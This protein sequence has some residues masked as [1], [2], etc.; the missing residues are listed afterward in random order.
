MGGLH[1]DKS[2]ELIVISAAFVIL[3]DFICFLMLQQERLLTHTT[4]C[5]A[6]PLKKISKWL[7]GTGRNGKNPFPKVLKASFSAELNEFDGKN[8]ASPVD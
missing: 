8:H 5:L 2:D 7:Y 1:F 3:P 6:P 4:L